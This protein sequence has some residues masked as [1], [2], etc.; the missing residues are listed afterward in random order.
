MNGDTT[1]VTREP[2]ERAVASLEREGY[3]IGHAWVRNVSSGED[4]GTVLHELAFYQQPDGGFSG[5]ELDIKAPVSNPFATRL[6]LKILTTLRLADRDLAALREQAV[7][8]RLEGWLD[9]AQS[10]D[11]DW[12]FAPDVYQHEL[13][14][15]YA[16][17]TFPSLNPPASLAG[18][19]HRLGLG[20]QRLH[21]RVRRLFDEKATLAEAETGE[22]Y[23]VLPYFEYV[24]A[25]PHP[26]RDAYLDALARNVERTLAGGGYADAEH[27][28]VHVDAGGPDLARRLPA[29][30]IEGQLDRLVSEQQDDG[31][32]ATP[33]DPAWRPWS[34]AANAV[35]LLRHG[36]A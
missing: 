19:A 2:I 23:T 6:A 14:P 28:F 34:T 32:W 13:A 21:E 7:V 10:E 15:W 35:T 17:W 31:G 16:G 3:R 18:L 36:R 5:L 8:Q 20:S 25:V 11:G 4:T 12:H 26:A 24:G 29:G 1:M 9:E 30:T 22:F 27:F 33:Y